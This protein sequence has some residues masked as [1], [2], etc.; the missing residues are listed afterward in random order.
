MGM[1]QID[2]SYIKG[3]LELGEGGSS[4]E[5]SVLDMNP[6]QSRIKWLSIKD[7][8]VVHVFT[9]S[10]GQGQEW[11]EVGS[12][13]SPFLSEKTVC[14]VGCGESLIKEINKEKLQLALQEKKKQL[15]L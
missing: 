1:I 6:A 10:T 5:I 8:F 13:V 15:I 4:T 3:R 11:G 9:G 12:G 2:I 7:M 14:S